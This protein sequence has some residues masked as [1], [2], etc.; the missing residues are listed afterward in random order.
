MY[1]SANKLYGKLRDG[2]VQWTA[3]LPVKKGLWHHVTLLWS[4]SD[5]LTMMLDYN[6][7]IL[8]KTTAYIKA[9]DDHTL[10]T[11]G[12]LNNLIDGSADASVSRSVISII[13]CRVMKSK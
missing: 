2:T 7:H 4:D 5:G 12:G 8:G 6:S 1:F 9:T 13:F 11:L 3:E 10:L